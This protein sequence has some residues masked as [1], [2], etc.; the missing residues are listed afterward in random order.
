MMYNF[1]ITNQLLSTNNTLQF[2]VKKW[3]T[4][5]IHNTIKIMYS[6]LHFCFFFKCIECPDGGLPPPELVAIK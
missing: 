4:Y 6:T 3:N 5:K 1:I 2:I